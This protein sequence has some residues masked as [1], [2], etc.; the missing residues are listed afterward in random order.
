MTLLAGDNLVWESKH[1]GFIKMSLGFFIFDYRDQ[2]SLVCFI[3]Q[4]ICIM[5]IEGKENWYNLGAKN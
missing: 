2:T 4:I 5:N 3:D 1:H